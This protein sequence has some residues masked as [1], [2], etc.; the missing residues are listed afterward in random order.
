MKRVL[1]AER[2][3]PHYRTGLLECIRKDLQTKDVHFD[4]IH[5]QASRPEMSKKDEGQLAW[6]LHMQSTRYFLHD[7]VVWQP[8]STKGYDLVIVDQENGLLFNHWLCRPWRPFR[9]A[10]FGHGANFSATHPETWRERYRRFSTRV[11]DWWF[12]YT[13]I[14]Q[15]LVVKAGFPAERITVVNNATDTAGLRQQLA[16]I[17]STQLHALRLQLGL[18]P[19]HTALF[20]G[21]L[22]E[23]KGIDLLLQSIRQ[24]SARLPTLRLLVVGD[25][26]ARANAEQSVKD[27]PLV[28]FLGALRGPDKAALMA[29]SDFM[30][31]P[32]AVGLAIVDAFAAGLP[33]ITTTATGHGPEIAYLRPNVNGALTAPDVQSLTQA[34]FDLATNAAQQQSWRQ[35]ARDAGRQYTQEGMAERFVHGVMEAL[36]QPRA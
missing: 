34:I 7:K 23:G 35:Q 33:L 26:P 11:P 20:L 28:K 36:L 32:G 10:F 6:A 18:Q 2:R 1:F 5:G 16:Q 4:F 14:S 15:R 29:V 21:S 25:G 31:M 27:L 12:A 13:D 24:L 19:G 17:S 9:L 22:Y 8:F 30:V 3:L